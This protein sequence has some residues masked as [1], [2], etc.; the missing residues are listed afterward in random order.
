MSD[1]KRRWFQ[2]HLSTLLIMV[3][4][5]A[6]LLWLNMSLSLIGDITTREGHMGVPN[7]F[8]TV[9]Y[10]FPFAGSASLK[11]SAPFHSI[12]AVS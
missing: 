5:A 4:C 10:G 3:F 2:I 6:A 1:N 9:G 8:C 7:H 12:L 11:S